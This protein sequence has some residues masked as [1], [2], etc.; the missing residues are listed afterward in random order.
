[1]ASYLI[2]DDPKPGRFYL[3]PKI[4]KKGIPGRPICSSIFHP[5]NKVGKFVDEHIKRYV[6]KV[7]SYVRDTQD[8]IA[9]IRAAP[10]LPEGAYLVTMD[11]VSLYTNIPNHEALIAIAD[12]LRADPDMYQIGP[13]ILRLAEVC[14]HNTNFIFNREHYMQIGGTS[15]G[16]PFAP[17]EANLFLGKLEEKIY[18]GTTNK[19]INPLRYIDDGFFYWSM[20]LENLQK[21]MEYMN[22][23]HPTIKF[24]FEISQIEIPFLDTLVRIDPTT[25]KMYTTLYSK[26]TDTHSYVHFTS[27]HNKST[28]TKSPFGQFLRLRRICTMDFDF[29]NESANMIRHY[30]RRGYP[31]KLLTKHRDK[32]RRYTQDQLLMVKDKQITDREIMVTRFNPNNPDVMRILRKHWNIIEF[33]DDCNTQFT[34]NPYARTKET[35]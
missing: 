1:M 9:K 22:T 29:D 10:P 27:S 28:L 3:L 30:I 14:L 12:H 17:S 20:G 7:K 34:N 23:Q 18:A 2:C 24:T 8:F 21:F 26:P 35:T 31:Q 5:T 25:R 15:M 33:S 32:A 19:P 13:Y 4:H 11:I 6:P 16:N